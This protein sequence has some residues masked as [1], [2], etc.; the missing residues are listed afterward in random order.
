MRGNAGD[1]TYVIDLVQHGGARDEGQITEQQNQGFDTVHLT[2]VTATDL[3]I[4]RGDYSLGYLSYTD[5]F[6]GTDVGGSVAWATIYRGGDFWGAIDQIVL[7]D[8]TIYTAATGLTHYGSDDDDLL[9]ATEAGD[10]LYGGLGEDELRG[11]WGNDTIIGGMGAD[12]MYGSLGDDVYVI[13]LGE[14]SLDLGAETILEGDGW[15]F[16]TLRLTSVDVANMAVTYTNWQFN[17]GL[18]DG[19][20]NYTWG[21]IPAGLDG[22]WSAFWS[23]FEQIVFDNGTIWSAS[24]TPD[25]TG[26]NLD[27]TLNAFVSGSSLSG[28]GG[29]DTLIGADGDDML[30]GGAGDDRITGAAG[31]DTLDGGTGDDSLIGGD[32]GDTYLVGIGDGTI[33]TFDESIIEYG[34]TGTDII[35]FTDGL[36]ASDIVIDVG[37]QEIAFGMDDGTGTV[38]WTSVSGVFTSGSGFTALWSVI[39]ELRF[40]DGTVIDQNT[41]YTYGGTAQDDVIVGSFLQA[42]IYGRGGNDQ[43]IGGDGVDYLFGGAGDDVLFDDGGLDRLNGGAGADIFVFSDATDGGIITDFEL[44]VDRIDL[45]AYYN[46]RDRLVLSDFDRVLDI[47]SDPIGNGDQATLEIRFLQSAGD[48]SINVSRRDGITDAGAEL[49]SFQIQID[50]GLSLPFT[51]DLFYF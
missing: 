16:D 31:A 33:G 30:F 10:D 8:G 21:T 15:G 26:T 42:D 27:E 29:D 37:D 17:F 18:G 13:G 35:H 48:L 1:D 11:G 23:R 20:G 25:V 45:S 40:D 34:G 12:S 5:W 2:C 32:G 51:T 43:L 9:W 39:E 50:D 41:V 38:L 3:I 19:A 49:V 4:A 24:N 44:G 46:P 22:D 36:T 6:F 28:F 14:G 7:D 47:V